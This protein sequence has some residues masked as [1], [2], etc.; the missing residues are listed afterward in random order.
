MIE[1]AQ[2]NVANT[3]ELREL[4]PR[5]RPNTHGH[6]HTHAQTLSQRH[7]QNRR[8]NTD[9]HVNQKIHMHTDRSETEHNYTRTE[10]HPQAYGA[11]TLF[12]QV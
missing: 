4:E 1:A 2:G 3:I 10:G 7:V 11:T 9:R 5:R 12:V 6:T 8:N